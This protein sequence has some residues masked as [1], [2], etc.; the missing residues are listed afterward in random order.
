MSV[1]WFL[2]SFCYKS[3]EADLLDL[4]FR[5][6]KRF[7]FVQVRL[8]QIKSCWGQGSFPMTYKG[9]KIPAVMISMGF[10]WFTLAQLELMYSSSNVG[11]PGRQEP[12]MCVSQACAGVIFYQSPASPEWDQ[13][14]LNLPHI[15][16]T[17]W[18]LLPDK[19]DTSCKHQIIGA[20][21]LQEDFYSK[22]HQTWC[23]HATQPQHTCF[24]QRN[25]QALVVFLNGSKCR[26]NF[27]MHRVFTTVLLIFRCLEIA[28]WGL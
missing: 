12:D 25:R 1:T 14:I 9:K 10:L 22:K 18:F 21:Y 4:V 16:C 24:N 7:G 23:P 28:R 17:V 5:L 13:K 15:S 2:V 26:M 6:W 27:V 11:F 19:S 8:L 20:M 3:H